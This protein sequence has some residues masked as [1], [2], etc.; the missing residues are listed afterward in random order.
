MQATLLD[1]LQRVDQG[2]CVNPHEMINLRV[3][4]PL[5]ERF[6]QVVVEPMNP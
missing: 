2:R 6:Q 4:H 3:V 1:A 5:R